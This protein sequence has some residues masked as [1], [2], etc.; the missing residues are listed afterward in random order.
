[1]DDIGN[2]SLDVI[3][4][5]GGWHGDFSGEPGNGVSDALRLGFI[6]PDCV[7]MIGVH[8]WAKIPTINAMRCP[9]VADAR[10]LMDDDAGTRRS[11]GCAVEGEGTM[12]LCPC[13]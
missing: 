6:G 10:L 8:S 13:G 12:E 3:N 1:M 2:A 7:A 5:G 9:T 4:G 11:N